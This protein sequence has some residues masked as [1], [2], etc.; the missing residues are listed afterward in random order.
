MTTQI[1]GIETTD[2]TVSEFVELQ[3][4]KGEFEECAEGFKTNI[5]V[6]DLNPTA[7]DLMEEW[8]F[9]SPSF[10]KNT[11]PIKK[12]SY[13]NYALDKSKGGKE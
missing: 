3:K 12:G 9:N 8:G 1:N 11:Q 4:Q 13:Y 5:T 7:Q 2:L 10:F 6:D